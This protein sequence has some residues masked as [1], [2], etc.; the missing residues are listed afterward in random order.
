MAV[1]N[2]LTSTLRLE[3]DAGYDEL[4]K[5][6]TKRK[7]Y[8][9]I[10]VGATSDAL[11]ATGQAIASLQTFTLLEIARIDSAALLA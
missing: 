7:N 5:V 3:Y 6:M 8:T 11:F 10:S 4:G 2:P 9:N 1:P